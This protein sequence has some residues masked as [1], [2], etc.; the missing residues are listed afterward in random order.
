MR[1]RG[2]ERI[3]STPDKRVFQACGIVLLVGALAVAVSQIRPA[4]DWIHILGTLSIAVG[5]V[6][7]FGILPTLMTRDLVLTADGVA[8][9]CLGIRTGFVRWEEITSVRVRDV[10]ARGWVIRY[11]GIYIENR[12]RCARLNL[13]SEHEGIEELLAILGAEAAKRDIPIFIRK[14]GWPVSVLHIPLPDEDPR[15]MW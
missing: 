14:M 13:T 9:S 10:S 4:D 6:A 11:Y 8:R 5:S 15:S 1:G 3:F 7:A 2:N 12:G